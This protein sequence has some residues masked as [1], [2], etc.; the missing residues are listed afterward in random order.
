MREISENL[1]ALTE[2][3]DSYERWGDKPGGFCIDLKEGFRSDGFWDLC[4]PLLDTRF[5]RFL[6]WGKACQDARSFVSVP[7]LFSFVNLLFHFIITT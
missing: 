5:S 2:E 7:K 4:H 3:N 1:G 6:P